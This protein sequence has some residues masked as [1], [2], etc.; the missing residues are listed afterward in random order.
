MRPTEHPLW[1]TFYHAIQNEEANDLYNAAQQVPEGGCIVEIGSFTGSSTLSLALGVEGRNVK[2]HAVDTWMGSPGGPD[3][4]GNKVKEAGLE[5]ASTLTVFKKNLQQFLET[6]TVII[7][8]MSSAGALMLD[9]PLQPNLLFI[10]GSHIYEDVLFDMANWWPRLQSGGIM[11]VHD[12]TGEP[13][14]HPQVKRALYTFGFSRGIQNFV[15]LGSISWI[16][17]P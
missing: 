12:S 1:P 3:E 5:Q 7:H 8:E 15:L 16:R 13:S 2:V 6:G 17:K 10:D 9:P 11:A 14:W 4:W